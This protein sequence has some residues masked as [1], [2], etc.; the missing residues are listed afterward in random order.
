VEN[1]N[2]ETTDIIGLF[3]TTVI[4]S[5]EKSVEFDGERKI[6]GITALKVIQGHRGQY[7][8]KARMRDFLLVI[9]N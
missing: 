8:S 9:S 3:S 1:W 6:R 7:Q 5:A 2:W 4:Q